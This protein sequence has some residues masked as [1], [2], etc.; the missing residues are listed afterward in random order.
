MKIL[1][2]TINTLLDAVFNARNSEANLDILGG[3]H[4]N[5]NHKDFL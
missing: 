1:Y 5:I 3:Q 2:E 4:I